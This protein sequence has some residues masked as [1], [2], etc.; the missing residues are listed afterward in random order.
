LTKNYKWI[1]VVL[2]FQF[3]SA[4]KSNWTHNAIAKVLKE[5]GKCFQNLEC[6]KSIIAAKI[7]L[8]E[9]IKINDHEL[10]ARAYNLIALN[11]EEFSDFDK[12]IL[13][14]NK[15]LQ[16]ALK[17][18]NDTIKEGIY[19]NIGNVYS[20]RKND[21]K[22]GIENYKKALQYIRKTKDTSELMFTNLNIASAYFRIEDYKNGLPYLQLA[23]PFAIKN[24]DPEALLTLYSLYGSYYTYYKDF[25]KAEANFEEA[26]RVSKLSGSQFLETFSINIYRDFSKLYYRMNKF[27][28]AYLMLNVYNE[29]HEQIYNQERTK[30]IGSLEHKLEVD[31][32]K[33]EIYKNNSQI[34][35]SR[36]VIGLFV[37]GFIILVILII[38]LIK[39]NNYKKKI[40]VELEKVNEE[41]TL[42]KANLNE[43]LDIKSQFISTVTHELRTPLYG[44]VGM[45]DLLISNPNDTNNDSYLDSLNFSAKYLLTLVND[46]LKINKLEETT[47]FLENTQFNLFAEINSMIY[48]LKFLAQKDNN[49]II[50]EFDASIPKN[51]IG[52]KNRFSQVIMNLV[53]NSIK[54]TKNGEI[55][56]TAKL[57]ETELHRCKIL[58]EV[59]DTGIG[60]SKENQKKIFDKFFQIERT[61]GVYEGTG[62][63]LYIVQKIINVFGSSIKVKS[64]EDRG[65]TFS[66]ILD[67]E[68]ANKEQIIEKN[69]YLEITKD[70]K[71]LV[72]DDN[73]IGLLLTS[74][75]LERNNYICKTAKSGV[76]ALE[77]LKNETFDI[78]LMDLNMPILSGFETAIKIREM[79]IK[80]TIIAFTA[81]SKE[82]VFQS[83]F[84]SG[85]NDIIYKPFDNISFIQTIEK[86]LHK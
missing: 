86:H 75:I 63:G 58:F 49:E 15:G 12:A 25:K 8:N 85:M 65:T 50:F 22:R 31:D 74:K 79:G 34:Q 77:M 39:T 40:N 23:E 56:I 21:F 35:Y 4:Q 36:I 26:I 59:K 46:V 72:I 13:Y 38:V 83:V 73:D 69:D 2:I 62:V 28:K 71:F 76:L 44:V 30:L 57:Q 60:I 78:I 81:A 11:L 67:F 64:K 42:A 43:A 80:T 20:Y 14:Y 6:E 48:S 32:F 47:I 82:Q 54:F 19:L 7:G 9:A 55:I 37:L 18:K 68:I 17:S 24:Q 61:G 70:A 41:L 16:Q 51:I 66:F 33:K 53:S 84:D 29:K 45:T 10:I 3:I 1:F 52:D 5:S 27:D